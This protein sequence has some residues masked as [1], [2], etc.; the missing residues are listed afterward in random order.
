MQVFAVIQWVIDNWQLIQNV[1]GGLCT[2]ALI[3]AHLWNKAS[4]VDEIEALKKILSEL[5]PG[6]NPQSAQE[7]ARLKDPK[8]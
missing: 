3:F 8:K 7:E 5:Q 2:L 6:Q 1:V 4:L